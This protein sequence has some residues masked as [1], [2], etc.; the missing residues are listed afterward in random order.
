MREDERYCLN[1]ANGEV[2]QIGID[3]RPIQNTKGL[4]A[5]NTHGTWKP[6]CAEGWDSH[7][8]DRVCRYIGR[9]ESEAFELINRSHRPHLAL[10]PLQVSYA[11]ST[12]PVF[13]RSIPDYWAGADAFMDKPSAVDFEELEVLGDFL[14]SYEER[15][16]SVASY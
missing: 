1:V 5:L 11:S 10:G 6:V 9:R 3:S 13:P 4:L 15:V 2:V 7:I 14:Q 16:K 8:N 12:K